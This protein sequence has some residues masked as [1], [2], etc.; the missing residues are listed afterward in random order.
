MIATL[1]SGKLVLACR[2]LMTGQVHLDLHLGDHA[3]HLANA[4]IPDW[5]IALVANTRTRCRQSH[6]LDLRTRTRT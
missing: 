6:S 1:R 3:A 5:I 4:R 2:A